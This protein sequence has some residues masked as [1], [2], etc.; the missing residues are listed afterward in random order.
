M[1]KFVSI[2]LIWLLV[3][4][5]YPSAYGQ[6]KTLTSEDLIQEEGAFKTKITA[7]V[8]IPKEVEDAYHPSV[9]LFVQIII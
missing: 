9:S 5:P 3:T 2:L 4:G 7:V 8:N 1:R 6:P